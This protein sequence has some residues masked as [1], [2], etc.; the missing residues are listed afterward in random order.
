MADKWNQREKWRSR[1]MVKRLLVLKLLE[2]WCHA[3]TEFKPALK[4]HWDSFLISVN[5][6]LRWEL[7]LAF[8]PAILLQKYYSHFLSEVYFTR[9]YLHNFPNNGS[10]S[11]AGWDVLTLQYMTHFFVKI[12]NY[13]GM[14]IKYLWL[15]SWYWATSFTLVTSPDSD[16]IWL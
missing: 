7:F 1:E 5:A 2:F 4:S 6:N 10:Y 9:R 13:F 14:I 3:L 15:I 12:L 11:I 8:Q 16:Y